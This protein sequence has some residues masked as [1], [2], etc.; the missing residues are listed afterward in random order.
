M[1]VTLQ[2]VTLHGFCHLS[3]K[4]PYHISYHTLIRISSYYKFPRVFP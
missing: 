3:G 2:V 1:L 4:P